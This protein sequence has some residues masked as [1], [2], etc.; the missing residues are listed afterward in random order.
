MNKKSSVTAKASAS[1]LLREQKIEACK[2]LIAKSNEQLEL[3]RPQQ[4]IWKNIELKGLSVIH[5]TYGQGIVTA[6]QNDAILVSFPCGEKKFMLPAAFAK[7]FL[8]TDHP[9][10]MAACSKLN[11]LEEQIHALEKNIVSASATLKVLENS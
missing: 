6:Q 7:G 5:R 2:Q 9:G 4:N 10:V 8:Q 1:R 11:S 3:L